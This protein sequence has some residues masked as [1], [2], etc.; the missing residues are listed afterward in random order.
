MDHAVLGD[1]FA[2]SVVLT[3]I[4]AQKLKCKADGIMAPELL[5]KVLGVRYA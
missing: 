5:S 1:G 3:T 2:H 4:L